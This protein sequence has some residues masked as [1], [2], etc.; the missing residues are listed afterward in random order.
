MS[1]NNITPTT[2]GIAVAGNAKARAEA[3]GRILMHEASKVECFAQF[4]GPQGSRRPITVRKELNVIGGDTVNYASVVPLGRRPQIGNSRMEGKEEPLQFGGTNCRVKFVR[5]SSGVDEEAKR[6]LA[7]GDQLEDTIV[8]LLRDHLAEYKQQEMAHVL[9][10]NATSY[11]TIRPN[12]R[13]NRDALQSGDTMSTSV[14]DHAQGHAVT[15][16]CQA[17]NVSKDETGNQIYEYVFL[18][19]Q[20]ALTN[21]K[22]SSDYLTA[23]RDAGVRGPENKMF[24]GGYLPWSGTNIIEMKLIDT[25]GKSRIGGCIMPRARLG[26][27]IVAGSTTIAITGG[28]SA[29]YGAD[30]EVMYFEDFDGYDWPFFL[31]Q[32]P[33]TDTDHYYIIICNATN[34]KWGMY[35][36]EG[37]YNNGNSITE[38]V[39]RLGP[40]EA[41]ITT[42]TLG[43]V[44]WDADVNTDAFP[45][46]S[47]IFQ[48]TSRGVPIGYS[49]LLGQNAAVRAYS[50]KMKMVYQD[51]DYDFQKGIGYQVVFG[52]N[53]W[54][55][56][57]NPTNYVLVEH[58]V[59]IPGVVTGVYAP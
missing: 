29:A 59:Q 34:G 21:L 35:E 16:G 9:R 56:Q 46:G 20:F 30:T 13:A 36:Y 24:K 43:D 2:V 37:Q 51:Q 27:A 31:D 52:Q 39:G 47:L 38:L 55:W 42:A 7:Q 26:T 58:A 17:P 25:L 40:G 15:I 5:H 14:I 22:T 33:T 3:W 8:D 48:C 44:T 49:A 28:G 54:K 23:N 19:S 10:R 53:I 57:T 45:S 12:F 6:F 11:N 18:A 32:T 50:D 41:G 1:V 4:E